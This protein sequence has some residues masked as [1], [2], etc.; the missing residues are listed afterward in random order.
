[1]GRESRLRREA[2]ERRLVLAELAALL[3]RNPFLEA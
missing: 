2:R 1:V 3:A